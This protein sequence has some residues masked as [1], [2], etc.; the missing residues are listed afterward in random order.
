M[1]HG[2]YRLLICAAVL[3]LTLLG[4][5]VIAGLFAHSD[6]PVPENVHM[7]IS[8]AACLILYGLGLL[9]ALWRP[10][11]QAH[12]LLAALVLAAS[13]LALLEHASGHTWWI[14]FPQL[15]AW[16]HDL[17]PHPGR[18]APTTALALIA[19]AGGLG[20]LPAANA[21]LNGVRACAGGA[22][23]LGVLGAVAYL[24]NLELLYS[25]GA[26]VRMALL[27]AAGVILASLGLY[28]LTRLEQQRHLRSQDLA[29]S[30]SLTAT[31][32]LIAISL[33]TGLLVYRFAS[34]AHEQ[35]LRTVM[36]YS[37]RQRAALLNAQ[38]ELSNDIARRLY[39]RA[40]IQEILE[41]ASHGQSGQNAAARLTALN[42]MSLNGIAIQDGAGRT[43]VQVGY[44]ETKP[45]QIVAMRS[46]NG[47]WLLWN[48]HYLYRTVASYRTSAGMAK[49]V[50]EQRLDMFD[51]IVVDTA[52]SQDLSG[53]YSLCGHDSRYLRCFPQL[54]RDQVI[55]IPLAGNI[56]H[57]TMWPAFFGKHGA[58]RTV[59]YS[60]RH[61]IGAYE[62]VNDTGLAFSYKIKIA[63]LMAPIRRDLE[64]SAL[65]ML[66]MVTLGALIL[67]W[68]THPL[69]REVLQS[70]LMAELAAERFR[71]AAEANMDAFIIMEALRDANGAVVDFRVVYINAEAERMWHLRRD[72]AIGKKFKDLM[73]WYRIPNYFESYKGVIETGKAIS[74]EVPKVFDASHPAWI[75]HEIVR[76][77]DSISVSVRDITQRKLAELDLVL[78]EALLKTVTDSIPALVAFVDKEE[79]YRYCNKAYMR[80]FGISPEQIIGMQ[81]RD[82]LGDEAYEAIRPHVAKA[83]EGQATSFERDMKVRG[84]SR[85]VEGRYIPQQHA[86][87]S[88]SG[89]YVM[90][91]DITQARAREMQLRSQVT[92][93][94]MTGLL[95]R[96]AFM[97]LLGD[98][99]KHHYIKR[100]ALALLFLDIDHFKLVNDTL[101]HAAGDELIR[102]FA[103][104]LRGNVRATDHV[105]R[106]G[107]DEFVILLIGLDSERTVINVVEKLLA[108]VRQSAELHGHT[109]NMT[110]SVGVAYAFTPDIT[111]ERLLE[112]ADEGLYRAKDA[113]RNTYRLQRV[114]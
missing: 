41:A 8:T 65:I 99:I 92:L 90:I 31:A 109:Y 9:L 86:D 62:P 110:T 95:N 50:L 89:F 7:V 28:A 84:E 101:G 105:A 58:L 78:R 80:L 106:L 75:H 87:G 57:F 3:A 14:D 85:Y 4:T 103:R 70:N 30:V 111:P 49:L 36:S 26:S 97:E 59:D 79:C 35:S 25:W 45:R 76:A 68:R 6:S 42:H 1:L 77:G 21:R 16:Q 64:R 34:D 54:P 51:R 98:E 81:M 107:G 55:T 40:D 10:N 56:Q 32:L 61:V 71:N 43:L 2:R 96:T 83:L 33:A 113:G 67:R 23:L 39:Q 73:S 104:R 63:D 5:S 112:I 100:Q 66:A 94:A 60:G 52:P 48:G 38:F 114:G 12:R 20:L 22:L 13:T 44:F 27:T 17:A 93:D 53:I 29:N 74:E 69:L 15:H 47:A 72:E 19:L 37:V 46:P 102:E 91:W 88:V 18:M 11:W 82:F 24:I 108:V